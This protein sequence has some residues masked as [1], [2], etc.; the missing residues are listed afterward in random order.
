MDEKNIV[1]EEKVVAEAAEPAAEIEICPET[2]E[3][4]A[5]EAE[6]AAVAAEACE[7]ANEEAAEEDAAPAAN[8]GD[9]FLSGLTAGQRRRRE[10]FDKLTTGL[11]ILLMASPVAILAYIFIWFI[12]N[13]TSR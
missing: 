7:C 6:E 10:I 1:E 3:C 13:I 5:A 8:G 9:D 12:I 4:E 2:C 11:L